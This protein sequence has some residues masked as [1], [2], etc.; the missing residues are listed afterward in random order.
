MDVVQFIQQNHETFMFKALK[1]G[2]KQCKPCTIRSY[3]LRTLRTD[4][5]DAKDPTYGHTMME[6]SRLKVKEFLDAKEAKAKT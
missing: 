4:G 1:R 2:V 6:K 5:N 3:V